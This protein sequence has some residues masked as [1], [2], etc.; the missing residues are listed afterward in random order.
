MNQ[1]GVL[2]TLRKYVVIPVPEVTTLLQ[3]GFLIF[4]MLELL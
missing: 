1:E 3:N 2:E 4:H